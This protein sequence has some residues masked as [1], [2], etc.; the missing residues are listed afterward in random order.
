MRQTYGDC[1]SCTYVY[2]DRDRNSYLYSDTDRNCSS[3]SHSN[4]K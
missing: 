1:N 2:S 3:K 4:A